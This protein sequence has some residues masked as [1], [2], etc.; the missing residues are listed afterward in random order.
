MEHLRFIGR[1]LYILFGFLSVAILLLDFGFYYPEEWKSYVTFSI[2]SLV[3]F[4]IY[5]NPFT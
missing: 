2:R 1:A 5:M 3:T 4:F